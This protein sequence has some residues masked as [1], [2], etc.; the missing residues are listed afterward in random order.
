M[1]T[2][3]KSG[4]LRYQ[5]LIGVASILF[6]LDQITKI[7][8]F[9]NLRIDSYDRVEVIEN[10]FY[11]IHVGNEGAA[12]GMFSGYGGFLSIVAVLALIAIYLL[13]HHLELHRL[14]MQLVFGLLVGGILGNT[15]DRLVHGHVIDF[16]DFSFPFHIP[17]IMPTGHYPT[18]NLA[19][20]G[21]VIGTILYLILSFY[22]TRVKST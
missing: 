13:R 7:L 3:T 1:H 9:K 16:L 17:Y 19:D 20:S 14:P 10:F 8:I 4:L 12:W 22:D 21:I 11:I 15:L 18:F 5:Y 2:K 6:A